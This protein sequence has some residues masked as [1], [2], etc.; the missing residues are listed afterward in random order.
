MG[1]I[2]LAESSNTSNNLNNSSNTSAHPI[3]VASTST[4]AYPNW[5]MD[6]GTSAHITN[7]SAN[8]D[9]TTHGY[10]KEEV[11]VGIGEKLAVKKTGVASLPCNHQNMSLKDVLHAPQVIEKVISVSRVTS[12]NDILI[13]FDSCGCY[14]MGKST[15]I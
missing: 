8:L 11:I 6:S 13:D 9:H 14:F 1:S 2:P 7:D 12:N 4:V 3:Y 10:G 5:Y 15:R